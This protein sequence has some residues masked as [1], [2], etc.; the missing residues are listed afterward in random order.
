MRRVG[1]S[2]S[3]RALVPSGVMT[4]RKSIV[5]PA[6]GRSP[7]G[8]ADRPGPPGSYLIEI[9]TSCVVPSSRCVT[10]LYTEFDASIDASRL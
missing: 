6:A 9:V 2:M 4:V 3:R 5:G 10:I 7:A 8:L 1:A